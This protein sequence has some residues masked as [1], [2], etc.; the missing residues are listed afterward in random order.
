MLIFK[1]QVDEVE[2]HSVTLILKAE[3]T[4]AVGNVVC[5]L[6]LAVTGR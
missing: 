2:P 6:T 4:S 3:S 1:R 5:G